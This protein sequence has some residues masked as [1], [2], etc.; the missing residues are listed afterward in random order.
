MS[1]LL[2]E[3]RVKEVIIKDG[4]IEGIKSGFHT[5]QHIRQQEILLLQKRDTNSESLRKNGEIDETAGVNEL[6]MELIA[7]HKIST[8]DQI[9]I[10]T[11]RLEKV[12]FNQLMKNL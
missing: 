4:W 3:K 6:Q 12:C 11:T 9:K 1:Y 2:N 7:D 5:S 10:G 8:I